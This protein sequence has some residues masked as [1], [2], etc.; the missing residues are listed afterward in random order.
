M[1]E[2]DCSP[3]IGS[4][5]QQERTIRTF[6]WSTTESFYR[7]EKSGPQHSLRPHFQVRSAEVIRIPVA[8]FSSA[9]KRKVQAIHKLNTRVMRPNKVWLARLH[10]FIQTSPEHL[11]LR[12]KIF[13][14]W[15]LGAIW[16]RMGTAWT[17][18]LTLVFSFVHLTSG[19]WSKQKQGS[20]GA[21][22]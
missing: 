12:E 7:D 5:S 9:A 20:H 16:Q 15:F 21:K 14:F 2:H 4:P 18:F 10:C 3:G 11:F 6:T 1:A 13:L 22:S 17:Y 8:N 19:L